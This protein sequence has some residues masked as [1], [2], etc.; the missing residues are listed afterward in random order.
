MKPFE[1]QK[2]GFFVQNHLIFLVGEQIYF[3][4]TLI[5]VLNKQTEERQNLLNLRSTATSIN[6]IPTNV[7]T[8]SV[9]QNV[10]SEIKKRVTLKEN[11]EYPINIRHLFV[12][13]YAIHLIPASQV[14]DVI[15]QCLISE[16]A[17]NVFVNDAISAGIFYW[18][19]D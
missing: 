18:C 19:N 10:I 1:L 13:L 17:G 12:K 11:N 2:I 3:I 4:H 8:D 14:G 9:K 15:K 7:V 16:P 6:S 5:Q